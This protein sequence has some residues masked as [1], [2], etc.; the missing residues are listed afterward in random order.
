MKAI[1]ATILSTDDMDAI[2]S[3]YAAAK[4]RVEETGAHHA[5][6]VRAALAKAQAVVGASATLR[7]DLKTQVK[8]LQGSSAETD[9]A[10]EHTV[11]KMRA[12]INKFLD[13]LKPKKK[14]Q[15]KKALKKHKDGEVPKKKS[16][17]VAFLTV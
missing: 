8:Q 13:A 5:A 12:A 14:T 10:V 15:K 16:K 17:K 2:Q 4:A 6:A 9:P 11:N 7:H 1:K 3:D